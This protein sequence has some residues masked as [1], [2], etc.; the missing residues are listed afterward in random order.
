MMA[1]LTVVLLLLLLLLLLLVAHLLLVS[2][3][4]TVGVPHPHPLGWRLTTV[5]V[6]TT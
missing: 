1:L 2:H 5:V 4:T 6:S 3:L